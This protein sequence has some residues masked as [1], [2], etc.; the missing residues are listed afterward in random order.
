MAKYYNEVKKKIKNNCALTFDTTARS[1]PNIDL[2]PEI[3]TYGGGGTN[4]TIAF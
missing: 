3:N 1:F 2:K 4:I